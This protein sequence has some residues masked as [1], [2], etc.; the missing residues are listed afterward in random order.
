MG[1]EAGQIGNTAFRL[2]SIRVSH[3]FQVRSKINMYQANMPGPNHREIM[4][5]P[6]AFG[7]VGLHPFRAVGLSPPV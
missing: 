3:L 4:R 6:L 1:G 7:R 2:Q 5:D